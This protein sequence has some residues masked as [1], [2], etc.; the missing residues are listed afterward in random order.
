MDISVCLF[1]INFMSIQSTEPRSVLQFTIDAVKC[2]IGFI[3]SPALATDFHTFMK[4]H[5]ALAI[6]PRHPKYV[7]VSV[8]YFN[9]MLIIKFSCYCATI[10]VT[11]TAVLLDNFGGERIVYRISLWQ[12]LLGRPRM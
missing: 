11:V 6:I 5:C 3:Y 7:E 10:T 8:P 9:A 12:H 2:V 1:A 4:S